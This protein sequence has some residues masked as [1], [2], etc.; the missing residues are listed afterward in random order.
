MSKLQMFVSIY[1]ETVFHF[2][3]ATS[4]L[5]FS[6]YEN[7]LEW[8]LWSVWLGEFCVAFLVHFHLV[9]KSKANFLGCS[10]LHV[11]S[12]HC[13]IRD[14]L[15]YV[16]ISPLFIWRCLRGSSDTRKT[17]T[18]WGAGNPHRVIGSQ[19]FQWWYID[20]SFLLSL[21]IKEA[22]NKLKVFTCKTY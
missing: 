3:S 10:G 6:F 5:L 15:W 17:A 1:F 20:W 2:H 7:Q 19:F 4:T 16:Y 18:D 11:I 22:Q 8:C 12:E 13:C 14:V 9:I 21:V